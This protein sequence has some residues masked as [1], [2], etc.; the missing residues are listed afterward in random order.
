MMDLE[1]KMSTHLYVKKSHLFE[2]NTIFPITMQKKDSKSKIDIKN[3]FLTVFRHFD[4]QF[5]ILFQLPNTFAV[6]KN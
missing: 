6:T 4:S 3:V 2:K 1:K 5:H